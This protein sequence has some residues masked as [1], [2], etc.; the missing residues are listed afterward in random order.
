MLDDFEQIA[1]GGYAGKN[2]VN[3]L[4]EFRQRTRL[5]YVVVGGKCGC[6]FGGAVENTD[7]IAGGGQV[8]AIG[9]PMAPSPTNPAF[10][11]ASGCS[12]FMIGIAAEPRLQFGE[13]LARP[14]RFQTGRLHLLPVTGPQPV[15]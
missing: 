8:P 11:G 9:A 10:S 4:R 7:Q 6:P 12:V 3:A 2:D 15:R 14:C 13:E 5:V 1:V